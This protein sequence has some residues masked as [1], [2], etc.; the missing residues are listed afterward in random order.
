LRKALSYEESA[1]SQ[2]KIRATKIPKKYAKE[3]KK[4]R[5]V[6]LKLIIFHASIAAIDVELHQMLAAAE[7]YHRLLSQHV[8][9]IHKPGYAAYT[10]VILQ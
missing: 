7:S 8:V 4:L 10:T 2:K 6:D 3:G 1:K 9:R 5:G